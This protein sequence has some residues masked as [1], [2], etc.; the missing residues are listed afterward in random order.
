MEAFFRRSEADGL[1]KSIA[2]LQ[3]TIR[4]SGDVAILDLRG[5]SILG[6]AGSESLSRCLRE[7]EANGVRKF[8]LNLTELIRIDSSGVGIIIKTYFYIRAKGGDLRLLR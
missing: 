7:L 3:I 8:L 6:P 5:K 4:K 1:S 2:G